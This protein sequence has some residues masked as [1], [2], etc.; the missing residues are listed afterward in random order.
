MADITP[1]PEDVPH[2]VPGRSCQDCTL[3]CKLVAVF[4]L[5]K[6]A[7]Q[8]CQHC[9]I[10][11]GCMI[12]D[13]RP[14]DCRTFYCGW[15]LDERISDDWRPSHCRM[16]VKFEPKRIV[17]HVDKDRRDQWRKEPFHSQI[18]AWA[19][20]GMAHEGE[21]IVWEGPNALRIH[22]VGEEKLGPST[23]R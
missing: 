4:E 17:I 13:T 2:L 21:V 19:R 12:Y 9:E 15:L 16:V 7:Q 8:W 5:E 3:C 10:G 20:A 18:R 22:P 14:A 6:P 11:K 1:R 23:R